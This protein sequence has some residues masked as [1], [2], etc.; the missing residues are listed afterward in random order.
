MDDLQLLMDLHKD[1]A[2]QG[3][4]SDA[5][6]LRALDLARLDTSRALKVADIG[7]GTGASTLVLARELDARITAVDLFPEFL[8]I[9]EARAG[10]QGL[11]GRI[12]TLACS[13]DTLP[14]ADSEYD[15]LWSEG[16][17][18][19][20]G[21]EAGITAWKPFL[22]P[23]GTLVVSEITWLTAE[24][25]SEIQKHWEREYPEIATAS[26]KLAVLERSGYSPLGYFV[27]PEDC[28][29]EHYYR[30]AERRLPQFLQCHGKSKAARALVAAEKEEIALYEKYGDYYSYGF[31]VARK[32]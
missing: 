26:E 3:P 1:G 22:R 4:G 8:D 9:L 6:T 7:C 27:L 20:I 29:T 11:A 14:F 5:Q 18:Y 30:P 12:T 19:N 32:L 21:F 13:M 25:P 2:R 17:V 24:R 16:A 28:W 23:G 15:L 31:Y 10:G